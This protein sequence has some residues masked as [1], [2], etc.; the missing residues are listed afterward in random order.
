M[1]V[2]KLLAESFTLLVKFLELLL[3]VVIGWRVSFDLSL[4][5]LYTVRLAFVSSHHQESRKICVNFRLY[6]IVPLLVSFQP[7]SHNFL[8]T[9]KISFG[10]FKKVINLNKDILRE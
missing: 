6:P 4:L 5:L 10:L 9:P 7:L 8:L 2:S 3:L 1:L